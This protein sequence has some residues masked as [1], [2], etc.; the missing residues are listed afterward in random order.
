MPIEKTLY[1]DPQDQP[2]A[3]LCGRCSGCLYPPSLRC[4]RCERRALYDP[5]G[6][7]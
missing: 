7:E 3:A 6:D 2:H 4:I 1:F 5:A